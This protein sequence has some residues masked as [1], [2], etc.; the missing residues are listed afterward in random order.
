[1]RNNEKNALKDGS[2]APNDPDND[3]VDEPLHT[4]C[5]VVEGQEYRADSCIGR[6]TRTAVDRVRVC[7]SLE[8]AIGCESDQFE[9]MM[10]N[11]NAWSNRELEQLFESHHEQIS[12]NRLLL[13]GRGFERDDLARFLDQFG[14]TNLLARNGQVDSDELLTTLQKILRSDIFGLEKYFPWGAQTE[15]LTVASSGEIE[16]VV[17]MS[18]EF[19][20]SMGV[21]R[22]VRQTF[23]LV[24]EELTSNALYDAPVDDAGEFRFADLD[25]SE[26]VELDDD[27]Q[28][29]VTFC[30]DGERIGV[31]VSDPFGSLTPRLVI[32]YLARCFRRNHDQIDRSAGG[33]GLGLYQSFEGLSH[34]AVN[35]EP[36]ERTELIGILHVEDPHR[37]IDGEQKSLNVFVGDG[38]SGGS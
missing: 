18:R 1:M 5:L 28:V 17:G 25:R 38:V 12:N 35:L 4:S 21:S 8:E 33:A 23:S 15:S 14:L 22:R 19:V 3:E 16:D 11:Y 13:Y 36:G 6:V 34:M 32:E 24:A 30:N 9:F 2:S 10:V 26:Q 7:T 27:E 37:S 20:G 29:E 31:S